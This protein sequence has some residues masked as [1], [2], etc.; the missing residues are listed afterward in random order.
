[1]NSYICTMKESVQRK[2][3]EINEL[4]KSSAKAG[5]PKHTTSSSRPVKSS[6]SAAIRNEAEAAAFLAE[7]DAIIMA[8]RARQK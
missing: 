8:A 2:I 1:M 3:D 5:S 4:A 7:L 6:L